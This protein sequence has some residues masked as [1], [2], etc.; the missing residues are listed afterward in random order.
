MS[1]HEITRHCPGR[2]SMLSQRRRRPR[3]SPDGIEIRYG[4]CSST[5]AVGQRFLWRSKDSRRPSSRSGIEIQAGP[6]PTRPGT[7]WCLTYAPQ[8][9]QSYSRRA[10]RGATPERT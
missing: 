10:S 8:P 4:R 1:N 2:P 6:T 9:F 7:H 3:E 5:M